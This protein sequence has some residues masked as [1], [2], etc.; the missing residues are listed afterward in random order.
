MKKRLKI[1]HISDCL[2]SSHKSWGGA[3]QACKRLMVAS[4]RAG[5]DVS[6]ITTT[7][8]SSLTNAGIAH[9]TAHT[10]D[11]F[12]KTGFARGVKQLVLPFDPLSFVGVYKA[13]KMVMP[14]V[15]HLHRVNELGLSVAQ[16][17][18]M[19]GI[20][21][22]VTIY[23]YYFFCPKETVV[24]DEDRKC[25]VY[26]GMRCV[27]CMG[28]A[29]PR[30]LKMLLLG[31]RRGV[32]DAFMKNISFH[33]LS[34]ASAAVL[35]G[36]GIEAN[37][38]RKILQVFPLQAAVPDN[39]A[40]QKGLILY[41]GWIQERKGLHVLI[42]A[43]PSIIKACP[44]A[45]LLAIGSIKRD[46]YFAKIQSLITGS[47]FPERI[48]LAGKKDYTEVS[49]YMG[50]AQVVV[51]PEQWENMSPVVLVEA[52]S[53]G[54]PVVASDIGGIPEFVV[55]EESGLL[56]EHSSPAAFA[57][58]VIKLLSDDS[59]AARMGKAARSHIAILMDEERIMRNYITLY[60]E[61]INGRNE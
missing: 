28:L 5:I 44:D 57:G 60:D 26:H 58:K 59:Y 15:V 23:D 1:C 42:K 40:V 22:V 4:V 16:C 31:L 24:D 51:I 56:A 11:S 8:D 46:E 33:V 7:A 13:L 2:P 21:V 38:I 34:T 9:Y 25:A 14:D 12:L 52:M 27:A 54:K 35:E 3:E 55:D 41:I 45:H 61:A 17:A 53:F 39:N 32:F 47:G 29:A 10:M 43:M 20:P 37:R 19:L 6:V 30:F 49:E 48:V 36:Y 50:K 18:Q